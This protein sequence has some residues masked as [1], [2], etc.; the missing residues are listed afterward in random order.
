MRERRQQN[1]WDTRVRQTHASVFGVFR[2]KDKDGQEITIP[3]KRAR[4]VLAM[5]C[6]VPNE[7]LERDFVSRLLWPGR[8]KAQAKASLR[9]CL[10]DLGR[11]LASFDDK[12][13]VVTR[14]QISLIGT[15][16]PTDLFCLEH[17][18]AQGNYGE[19]CEQ[20][21]NIAA[22]PLLDQLNFGEA[23]REWLTGHR[24]QTEQRLK[25]AVLAGLAALEGAGNTNEYSQL[26][27]AWRLRAPD[28]LSELMQVVDE[29]KNKIAVLAFSTLEQQDHFADGMVDEIIT[30]LGQVPALMVAG[31][32]SSFGLKGSQYSLPEIAQILGVAHLIEGSVQRQ[33]NE[34]RINVRLIDGKTGFETWGNRYKGTVD[35]I[36]LLQE[37]VAGAVVQELSTA[38]NLSLTAP[39]IGEMSSNQ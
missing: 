35:G 6:L 32:S 12:V 27:D 25:T 1:I 11:L 13:L 9:Q 21:S 7:P 10:L 20:L 37:R 8:F 39:K 18:L 15:A 14:T 34:V 36:F 24:L 26:L 16:I 4:A 22:R 23:F 19:T 30:M 38:L 5:L 29:Q 3:N 31:R 33:G 17:A 2:L 28:A